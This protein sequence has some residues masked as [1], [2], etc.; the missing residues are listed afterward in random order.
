MSKRHLPFSYIPLVN[1]API[2]CPDCGVIVHFMTCLPHPDQ[3]KADIRT[4]TC[5]Q[6]GKQTEMTVQN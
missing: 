1:I 4:F 6:C 2:V 3:L 5:K